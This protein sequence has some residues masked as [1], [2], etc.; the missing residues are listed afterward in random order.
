[1]NR[2]RLFLFFGIAYALAIGLSF[3]PGSE[4][5]FSSLFLFSEGI[6]L[7][8]VAASGTLLFV[9]YEIRKL[10]VIYQTVLAFVILFLS[11]FSS[12]LWPS[13]PWFHS[14]WIVLSGLLLVEFRRTWKNYV[15]LAAVGIALILSL[16]P[17]VSWVS[18]IL[19]GL[20]GGFFVAM[21]DMD[22][23]R[24]AGFYVSAYSTVSAVAFIPYVPSVPLGQWVP[25][26]VLAWGFLWPS[27]I[28]LNKVQKK[29][30]ALMLQEQSLSRIE[31][32]ALRE[33]IR[34]H[35][36][37]NALNNVRVAYHESPEAGKELLDELIRLETRIAHASSKDLILITEEIE[38]IEGLVRLFCIERKTSILFQSNCSNPDLLIPPML[39]EPLVENSLQ[40]SGILSQ[41]DGTVTI[42]QRIEFGIVLIVITDNGQGQPLPSQSRGIGLSN[43]MTRVSLLDEGW[44]NVSS[45]ENGTVVEIRFRLS[46][47]D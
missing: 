43:V 16:F 29:N 18:L 33:E 42:E 8:A 35:F 37:L 45:D 4:S 17:Q 12:L 36:L 27:L 2:K 24:Y 47:E 46:S 41:K 34:P 5:L 6:A 9:L 23:G 13:W 15:N 38:I 40:H 10:N 3:I 20:N 21:S 31:E 22:E 1:M 14:V 39:L 25:V 19:M 26:L 32:K 28:H 7:F 30:E 44:M 11:I